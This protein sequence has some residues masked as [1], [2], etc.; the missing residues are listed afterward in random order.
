MS[1]IMA[2]TTTISTSVMPARPARS[3]T[4]AARIGAATVSK[5]FSDT[6]IP[7]TDNVGI[8]PFAARLS[9]GAEAD[10]VR[11]VAVLTGEPVDIVDAP[12]VLGH[13]LWK[14]WPVPLRR[15]RRFQT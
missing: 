11:L 2:T 1:P 3:L 7:P 14:I 9:V 8:D 6:L 4:I 10:D 15:F 13:V 12:R 5:R